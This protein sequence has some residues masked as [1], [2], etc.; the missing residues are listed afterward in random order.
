MRVIVDL[1][2]CKDDKGC[3]VVYDD[4][5]ILEAIDGDE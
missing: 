5:D 4:C 3:T 2:G 1:P